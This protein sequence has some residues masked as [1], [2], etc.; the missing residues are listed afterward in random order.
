MKSNNLIIRLHRCGC[1]NYD[2]F[3]IVVCSKKTRRG[4]RYIERLGYINPNVTERIFIIDSM[5]LA[6]WA[7]KGVSINYTVKKYLV[8]AL[9]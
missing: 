3:D 7:Q 4:G 8:K 2:F 5:R 6:Y 1:K 9:I